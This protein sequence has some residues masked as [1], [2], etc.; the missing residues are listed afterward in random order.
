MLFHEVYGRYFQVIGEILGEAVGGAL[1]KNRLQELV[2]EKAFAEST[3]TIPANL[4]NGEWPLLEKN[5]GTPLRHKPEKPLTLLEKRWLKSLLM[6]SRIQLFEP[7]QEGLEGVEP[8]FTPNMLVYFDRYLD[9]DPFENPEYIAHFKT[10]LRALTEKRK[11]RVD[12]KNPEGREFSWV[13]AP[14]RLEYSSK[15][16]KFRLLT[17]S[18]F[19]VNLARI[20]RCELLDKFN[21][22]AYKMPLPPA[23]TLVLE[24]TDHRNALERVMLHFSHLE[25]ETLRLGPKLYRLTL[26]YH[27]EDETELLIRVLSFGPMIK[28]VEPESFILE[29]KKRI[30]NQ[31]KLESCELT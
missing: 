12:F 14:L 20:T 3:L 22:K 4:S 11:L 25:K 26:H 1:T 23:K 16:D 24:L 27:P 15:D 7:S 17:F 2:L 30:G 10:V 29:I 6:D 13:C 19:T 8:I 21:P 18:D 5:L 31:V 28:A 9:G